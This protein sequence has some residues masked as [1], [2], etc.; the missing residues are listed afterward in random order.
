MHSDAPCMAHIS[1]RNLTTAN[2]RDAAA[3]SLLNF[4]PA[5]VR[6]SVGVGKKKKKKLPALMRL[7]REGDKKLCGVGFPGMRES[8]GKVEITAQQSGFFSL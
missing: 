7:S 8:K 2:L 4:Y 6:K 5:V 1:S 3:F